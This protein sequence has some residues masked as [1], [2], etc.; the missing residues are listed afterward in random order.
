M[1]ILQLECPGCGRALNVPAQYAGS[2]GN[3]KHC[4][5]PFTV[6]TAAHA[7]VGATATSGSMFAPAPSQPTTPVA[8]ESGARRGGRLARIREA[9]RTKPR[10]HA[11]IK[12]TP[13]EALLAWLDALPRSMP[14]LREQDARRP[15]PLFL[16][17]DDFARSK[18]YFDVPL[19]VALKH[20][21]L[22]IVKTTQANV[23]PG[24]PQAVSSGKVTFEPSYFRAKEYPIIR[25]LFTI[26][27]NPD[28]PLK[29]ESLPLLTD[30]NSLE[31]FSTALRMRRLSFLLYAG[32]QSNH[33]ATAEIGLDIESM[34]DLG[35]TLVRAIRQWR[36]T[37]PE[38]TAHDPAVKR[39]TREVPL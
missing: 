23:T 11:P 39:F 37:R 32:S 13:L 3:C 9:I 36:K 29:F 4:G 15:K 14:S 38:P 31:F 6:P 1:S 7:L 20:E 2:R 19:L 35:N 10:G 34:C 26:N 17:A 28:R 21:A 5:T 16:T 25:L 27:D 18:A 30:G 33:V 12:A 22:V 8:A 24:T